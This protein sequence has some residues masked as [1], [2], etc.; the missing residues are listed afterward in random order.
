MICNNNVVD[1]MDKLKPWKGKL[2]FM[3]STVPY[4]YEMSSYI[5]CVKPYGLLHK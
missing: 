5:D 4:A 3:I 2:D 1:T